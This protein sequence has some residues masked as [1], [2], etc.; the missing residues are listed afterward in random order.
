MGLRHLRR[1]LLAAGHCAAAP[2]RARTCPADA[3]RGPAQ[4]AELEERRRQN[5]ALR[6]AALSQYKPPVARYKEE[7]AR[8]RDLK[9][10]QRELPGGTVVLEQQQPPPPRH[11]LALN[12]VSR[13]FRV[14]KHTGVWVRPRAARRGPARL[15]LHSRRRSHQWMGSLRGR[16]A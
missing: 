11:K 7:L 15:T 13:K 3:P 16:A 12:T 5:S 14:Y 1:H 2:A 8:I 6:T 10:T 9:R 4:A